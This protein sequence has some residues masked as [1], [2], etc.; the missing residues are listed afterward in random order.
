MWLGIAMLGALLLRLYRVGEFAVF[1]SD[2]AIDSFAVKRILEG[3]F[4]L[5]GP[6]SSVGGFFNGPIVYYLMTPF[7]YLFKLDPLSGTHF[8]ILLQVATIPF[9]FIVASRLV[10]RTTG[11]VSIIIF[12]LS[13]LLI[14]YS[15]ATFNSYP[16]IF[17][18]TIVL[19]FLSDPS[20]Q[21]CMSEN[22]KSLTSKR[23]L[24]MLTIAGISLG[25]LVQMHY[26]L[27]IYA[28]F[29][30]LYVVITYRRLTWVVSFVIGLGLG[31]LP[32]LLF[33][34]RHQFFN[35]HA[36]FTHL[37][38]SGGVHTSSIVVLEST[39]VA[40]GKIGG[41]YSTFGGGVLVLIV[42]IA[43]KELPKQQHTKLM[44][45][46]CLAMLV[47]IVVY[48]GFI[49]THYLIGAH[50]SLIILVS[51]VIARF[52]LNS[53]QAIGSSLL[54]FGIV[55]IVNASFRVLPEQDG[56]GLQ[57]QRKVVIYIAKHA[58]KAPWN[59]TQDAQ[60]DN[61]AMPLRY[62][63]ALDPNIIQPLPVEDYGSN[64]Y[65]FIVHLNKKPISEIQTWEVRSF[66]KL[67]QEVES[68]EINMNYTLSLLK[69]NNTSK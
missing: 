45:F 11:W 67:F 48:R 41:L 19:F 20:L 56:L 58:P 43:F 68:T 12:A 32:F 35:V 15:R 10:N 27:Y 21:K 24:I 38:Q 7:Y 64:E 13:P 69:K 65:L 37:V 57:D 14:Y 1:L 18:S 54:A 36:I 55:M 26:L 5:L 51:S 8:Q 49:Q 50:V 52:K 66:G 60:Q 47:S 40:L 3:S 29:Y 2:Q 59:I 31:I 4:T 30:F 53:K 17:F 63:L 22:S 16:A 42:L 62:L 6:R 23:P 9:L 33:E 61:R 46:T 34:I 39:L 44:H 28:F 25:F